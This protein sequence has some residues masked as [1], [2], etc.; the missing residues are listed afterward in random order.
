MPR[1]QLFENCVLD[2]KNPVKIH[3]N[4]SE[5]TVLVELFV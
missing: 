1:T 5:D 4:I 2:I 3:K